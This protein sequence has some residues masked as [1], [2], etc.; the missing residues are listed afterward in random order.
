MDL[1]AQALAFIGVDRIGLGDEKTGLSHLLRAL[2]L[3][4][5]ARAPETV[6]E[7]RINLAAS[8]CRACHFEEALRVAEAGLAA[9]NEAGLEG[10][11]GPGLAAAAAEAMFRLGRWPDAL[12]VIATGLEVAS[13]G[14][15]E[16]ALL[17]LR[18]RIQAARGHFFAAR[19]MLDLAE[20]RGRGLRRADLVTEIA[21]GRAE[22]CL[23][24]GRHDLARETLANALS[25]LES[26]EDDA[27]R[28]AVI[29]LA[30]RAEA[31]HLLSLGR[32]R[33]PSEARESTERLE[34]YASLARRT[35]QLHAAN[36]T[37]E[38]AIRIS[39]ALAQ[40]ERDRASNRDSSST[41]ES[42][43]GMRASVG[44]RYGALYARWRAVQCQLSERLAEARGHLSTLYVESVSLGA[45]PLRREIEALAARARFHLDAVPAPA[46]EPMPYG[47][48][49][50]EVEVLDLIAAGMTNREIGRSLFV[51]EKT[52]AAHVYH[53]LTK[54]N[55]KTRHEAVAIFKR[56]ARD[57]SERL[58]GA[59]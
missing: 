40:A 24:T 9:I 17:A 22:L 33:Y 38:A 2:D 46:Q 4:E 16:M 18:G 58:V 41:W 7:I 8:L 13:S 49:R 55:A 59:H 31:E 10:R 32:R 15:S 26:T 27:Q 3:A 47:L 34:E 48:T 5:R 14:E 43:A 25:Y 29:A 28:T 23:W 21:L 53:I 42:I 51:T 50:R 11:A 1:V 37:A 19:R 12:R 54:L 44:D 35:G 52:A 30:C 45:T 57:R 6:A 20:A 39:V 36:D 56:H